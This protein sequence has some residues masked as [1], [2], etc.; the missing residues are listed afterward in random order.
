MSTQTA[1][2]R[3]TLA[4][5]ATTIVALGMLA[6][7]SAD[8]SAAIDALSAIAPSSAATLCEQLAERDGTTPELVRARAD[9][10]RIEHLVA[11]R[12]GSSGAAA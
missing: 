1:A 12:D 6:G 4:R 3:L 11:S 2:E 10:Y 7:M 8:P 5:E 9:G